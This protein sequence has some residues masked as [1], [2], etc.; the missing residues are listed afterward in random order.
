LISWNDPEIASILETKADIEA[1][2]SEDRCE[3]ILA[4]PMTGVQ[5]VNCPFID[6]F[7]EIKTNSTN[8]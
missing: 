2:H 1:L 7:Q 8:G 4:R 3:I 6:P 5:I